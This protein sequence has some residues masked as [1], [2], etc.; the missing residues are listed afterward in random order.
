MSPSPDFFDPEGIGPPSADKLGDGVS[1]FSFIDGVTELKKNESV[2]AFYTLKGTEEFLKDHF[3]RFP[4]MPGVLMLESMRQAAALLLAETQGPAAYFRIAEAQD[5][6]F[7]QFVRPGNRLNIFARILKTE[8]RKHFFEARID[9]EGET[10][11]KA[12]TA[13]FAL[14]PI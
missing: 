14:V 8:N 12:L 11:R 6:K 3:D 10:T 7:G 5:L 4:V 9:L 13:N 2:T 1:A